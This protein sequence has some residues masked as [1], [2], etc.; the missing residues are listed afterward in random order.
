[1]MKMT[2]TVTT[3]RVIMITNNVFL[4]YDSDSLCA[5]D[6]FMLLALIMRTWKKKE[7]VFYSL[8]REVNE[9]QKIKG[10]NSHKYKQLK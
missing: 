1:M 3:V 5:K 2:V 6:I 8:Y 4:K 7:A 9:D 10:I